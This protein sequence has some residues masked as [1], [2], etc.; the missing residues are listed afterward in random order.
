MLSDIEFEHWCRRLNLSEQA[1]KVIE[2]IRTS[3]P[4]RRVGGGKKN[5]SGRY[6]SSKMGVS[7][8][9]ESHRNELAHIYKLETDDDVLEY[10]DQPPPIF[11]DYLSKNGR[12]NYHSHT[13]DFFV[14]RKSAAGWEECSVEQNLLKKVQDSPN[15][16]QRQEDGTWICPPG[17]EY[18]AQFGLYYVVRSSA[19]I[20]SIFLRN[21][22]WLEDYLNNQQLTVDDEITDAVCNLVKLQ[23]GISLANIIYQIKEASIDDL[24][25]LI[26]TNQV[27]VDLNTYLLAQPEKV[28]VF[29]DEEEAFTF[30]Q[31]TKVSEPQAINKLGIFKASVGTSI[32]WDG[33]KWEIANT[34]EKSIALIT[35]DGKF[36]DLPNH[37]FETL[38]RDK[39]ITSLQTPEE[40]TINSEVEELLRKA[41]TEDRKEATSRYKAIEAFLNGNSSNKPNRSQRRWIASYRKA[42][43]TY[44]RG[45]IGLLP[46][47]RDKGWRRQGIPEEVLLFMQQHIEINYENIKQHS[48]RHAYQSFKDLCNEKGYKPP[49]SESY[50]QAVRNRPQYKQ[51]QKR[52]G[53]RAAYKEEPFYWYI[54]REETPPHG[55]R[56]FEICHIDHTEVDVELLSAIMLKLGMDISVIKEKASMGRPW[57]TLMLDAYSR[58]IIAA[59]MT[60][61]SPSYRSNMMILK[62]CVQRY[63]RLPQIIVVDGGADFGGTYFETLL[64]YFRVT[65]KERPAAK[66]RHGSVIES[67]FGV[68]DKEFW[69][70]LMGNTQ[71]TKNVRQV[72]KSVNP[73]NNAVWTLAKLYSYFC[74]YCYEIYDTCP[75]PALRMSPR[76]AFNI[77]TARSGSRE[78]TFIN[79]EEFKFLALPSPTDS[80]GTRKITQEGVK[81]NYLYYW[82]SCF[83]RFRN[84]K[85]EVKYDPFDITQAYAY[86]NGEWVKCHSLYLRELEGHSEREL[87]IAAAELK[88][89]NRIQNKQFSDITG[90]KLAEFF[91][92]IEMEE[93]AL[94]P[95][96]LEAKKA[97]LQQRLRD[98]ELKQVH[99]Q[100]EGKIDESE[101]ITST[102]VEN[103]AFIKAEHLTKQFTESSQQELDDENLVESFEPLEEW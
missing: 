85:V 101:T 80:A 91:R 1:R 22:V 53:D 48:I 54:H 67:Y 69:H 15:R 52:M 19:E 3:E 24:N 66:A 10:Y 36:I 58:R 65:K 96:W 26:A 51:I 55:D 95:P 86:I 2:Q 72:T 9:F 34:G 30:N 77:G 98:S 50:R 59:Y 12:R 89:L 20:N 40:P 74:E 99:A 73:K 44:G 31:I 60:F 11:L 82:H 87:M 102:N 42:E 39:K 4:S 63:G 93:A 7:I 16:W 28:K 76:E 41:S 71:I 94:A 6:P 100:I 83:S 92:R 5:V 88:K 57:L 45:F 56:P 14:I 43:K 38:V 47:H 8:Q 61:D 27:Y 64:A 90:K 97:V 35:Q 33:S 49:S 23:P 29:L 46:K 78:H 37:V 18:A 32:F 79:E 81:I 21:F 70:N 68:A 62:M 25:T 75:H 17:K 84:I 103:S 13:P